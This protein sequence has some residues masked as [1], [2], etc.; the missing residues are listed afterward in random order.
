M[1]TKLEDMTVK[2]IALCKR[3]K[4]RK[5]YVIA[6]ADDSDPDL[7]STTSL[8]SETDSMNENT[9]TPEQVALEKAQAE[10]AT[11]TA[12]IAELEKAQAE[13]ATAAAAEATA[14][15]A[16][17]AELEKA[18]TESAAKAVELEKALAAE[19]EAK[20]VSEAI[21]KAAVDFKNLPEAP[22]ALGPMLMK[23]S[24]A[25]PAIGTAVEAILK[26]VDALVAQSLEKS[27]GT[28]TASEKTDSAWAEIE[29]RANGLV[30]AKTVK[31]F[32]EG[33]TKALADDSELYNQ[34]EAEKRSR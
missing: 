19:R 9:P 31:T 11:A 22:S 24:K 13:A 8:P 30:A 7:S 5:K 10:A 29:K 33:V 14:S 12:R 3:A 15:A 20:A 17:L 21:S 18:Q 16:R 1:A 26:K 34:H 4:N 28:S 27:A 32:A 2:E 23:I 25:D 6:K